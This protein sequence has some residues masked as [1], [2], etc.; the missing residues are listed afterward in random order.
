MSNKVEHCKEQELMITNTL[1]PVLD[2]DDVTVNEQKVEEALNLVKYF[3]FELVE[4][5]IFL[6]AIVIGVVWKEDESPYFRDI[7][8]YVGRG[9][10][11]NGLV[12]FWIFYFIS[13]Y[14]GVKGYNVELMANSEQQ[15]KM[16]FTDVFNAIKEAKPE[17]Q[18]AIKAHYHATLEV[19]TCKTTGSTIKYNTS[20][21]RGKDSKR[22]GCNLF[23]EKHEYTMKDK[24][25][26]DTLSSGLGKVKNWRNIT[27]STC[28]HV[29]E[30]VLDAEQEAGQEILSKYDP[31]NRVFIFWCRIEKEEEWKNPDKWVK[32]IPSLRHKQFRELKERVAYEVKDMSNNMTY[33]AEFMAKRMN[34]PVGNKDEQIATPEDVKATNQEVPDLT[35]CSC[36]GGID[37]ANTNDFVGCALLFKQNGK[38]YVIQHTFIC[39]KSRDLPGIKAPLEEWEKKGDV[40]FINDVEIS[41]EVVTK[42][43]KMQQEYYDIKIIAIDKFR[44]TLMAKALREIGFEFNRGNLFTV[45]PSNIME[46]IPVVNSW[47]IKHRL[48]V[49][50][51][52]VFRWAMN[53]TKIT[54]T[55]NNKIY[56]KIEPTYRKND[57]WMA[58]AAAA[59]KQEKLDEETSIQI[60][61]LDVI[62][63]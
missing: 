5:E 27:I 59:T 60:E 35:K 24:K 37:Y 50:D 30:G 55:K 9:S 29:R 17:H 20:S 13:P 1:I 47:I 4:W 33:F 49:G 45:R 58:F 3:D 32:A 10:G 12:S 15:A 57:T 61:E 2:R 6:T 62:S 7:R 52:P 26:I 43:F 31:D 42:W 14:H 19:I 56:D 51:T 16:S 48:A 54:N 34:Y 63:L 40:E 38:I 44:Y 41:P 21:N 25:N 18:K 46:I 39:K 36:I 23:D 8:I 28:G 11:K 53:N 22:T